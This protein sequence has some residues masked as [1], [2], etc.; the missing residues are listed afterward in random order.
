[1][2]VAESSYLLKKYLKKK[3]LNNMVNSIPSYFKLIYI[4]ESLDKFDNLIFI[5]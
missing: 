3:Y 1:M 4:L 2:G 5:R